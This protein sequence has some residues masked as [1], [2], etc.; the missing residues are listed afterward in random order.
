MFTYQIIIEYDG[1]NFAGWQKQKNSPSIQQT[2]EKILTKI[3]KEKIILYGSG[4]TDAGVHAT[5]QS[6][7]FI[8]NSKIDNK[9]FF[10][11]SINFFLYKKK[12][13][14]LKISRKKLNFHAR[15]NANKREYKYIIINRIAPPSLEF[16]REWHIKSILDYT[17]MKKAAKLLEGNKDFSTFRSSSCNSR[18]PIKT[19]NEAIVKKLGVKIIIIFKSK[20][21][22]QKQVRSMVGCLKFVGEGKWSLK[23]FQYIISSKSRANCAPPAPAYGLYL[24]K[25]YY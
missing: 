15:F 7:H 9:F 4:R 6:A 11:N 16:N 20:S 1:T 18:S 2:I 17:L 10:I 19:L 14:I 8:S 22:L 23:K 5:G 13:S 12:I 21:F 25:V 24:S 3:L